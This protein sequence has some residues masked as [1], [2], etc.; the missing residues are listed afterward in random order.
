MSKHSHNLRDGFGIHVY[1]SAGLMRTRIDMAMPAGLIAQ[2]AEINLQC[3]HGGGGENI[4][5]MLSQ[6]A[7]KGVGVSHIDKSS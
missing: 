7:V 4:Y 1:V 2:F 6:L 3:L 5:A